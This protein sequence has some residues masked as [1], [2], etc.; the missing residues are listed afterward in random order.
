[1]TSCHSEFQTADTY[2]PLLASLHGL[3]F[4]KPWTCSDMES[5]LRLPTT[6]AQFLMLNEQP[7]GFALY[8]QMLDEAEILT[9]GIVPAQRDHGLGLSLIEDGS[10]HLRTN[11]VRRLLLEVSRANPAA[12]A[13]YRKAGFQLIGERP[14]YYHD[15]DGTADALLMGKNL[16]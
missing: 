9:C 1:M 13:L 12:I 15:R 3:C 10:R 11:G 14:A 16:L 4:D 6:T 8:Q 5:L 7:A 2:A